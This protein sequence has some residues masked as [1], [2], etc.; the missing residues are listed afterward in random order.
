MKFPSGII[1]SDTR[2]IGIDNDREPLVT[3]SV[4][5]KRLHDGLMDTFLD[6]VVQVSP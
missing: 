1:I 3:R 4:V 5:D 2:I 6:G